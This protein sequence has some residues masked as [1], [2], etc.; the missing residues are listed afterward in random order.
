MSRD[1]L[2]DRPFP[3]AFWDPLRHEDAD[4]HAVTRAYVRFLAT[5]TPRTRRGIAGWFI[6]GFLAGASLVSAATAVHRLA[7]RRE[8]RAAPALGVQSVPSAVPRERPPRIVPPV[9]AASS[10]SE[11]LPETLAPQPASAAPQR[12]AVPTASF[13]AARDPKWQHVAA[14]LRAHDYAAAEASLGDLEVAGPAANREAASLA[15]AQVLIAQ[16]RTA[17]ARARLE[18]L[19]DHGQSPL[20]REKAKSLISGF[21]APNRSTP[22]APDTH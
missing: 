14:A 12:P 8:P 10:A 17:E 18:R 6:A 21:A 5:G 2:S 22:T 4:P 19:R 15:L 16:G 1:P 9:P 13:D 20:V 3:R 7:E 11:L